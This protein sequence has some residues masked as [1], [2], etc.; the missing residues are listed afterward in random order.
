MG[1]APETPGR[2][3]ITIITTGMRCLK[4]LTRV[5]VNSCYFVLYCIY[6]CVV[7]LFVELCVFIMCPVY[8]LLV[9][10]AVYM[11]CLLVTVVLTQTL[12]PLSSFKYIHN[13]SS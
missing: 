4:S 5:Q 1:V 2:I 9:S 8:N 12:I 10:P 11:S 13:I 3:L 7:V 6:N